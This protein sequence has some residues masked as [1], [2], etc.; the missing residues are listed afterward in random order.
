M[1]DRRGW[2]QADFATIVDRPLQAINEII[3]AKKSITPETARAFAQALGTSAQHWLE[4]ESTYRL[5]LL[6]RR[7][8]DEGHI[9]RRSRLY[10]AAP[11]NELLKR[12][13][14]NATRAT[15]L[16]ELER[17]VCRFLG[18]ASLDERPEVRFVARKTRPNDPH[19][20]AQVAWVRRVQAVASTLRVPYFDK[21]ALGLLV[22]DIP[23]SSRTELG[24]RQIPSLLAQVGIRFTVVEPLPNT[25]IDGAALW[26][27]PSS[28]VI[29]VTLRF[30]RV[31]AFWF[32]L[33][34]ELAHVLND[35]GQHTFLDT[36]LIGKSPEPT[37]ERTD[38]ERRADESAAEWLIPQ[39][40]FDKFLRLR[41]GY[42]SR[43]AILAFAEALG[44]HPAIVVGRLQHLGLVPWSH[45]RNLL[46]RIRGVLHETVLPIS[47]A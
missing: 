46:T 36:E 41:Q 6:E 40:Q 39:A 20:S 42:L 24:T 38:V 45:H 28:P 27:T 18:V 15:A 35:D 4:L 32:T 22:G 2:T 31:D 9:S 11:I 14:I 10:A 25:R 29:A 1:L 7:V 12:R 37:D 26:L 47:E 8:H 19:T 21:T 16:D 23:R 5:G 17:E 43:G 30:D 13:W 34:H 3:S 33:M 44:I